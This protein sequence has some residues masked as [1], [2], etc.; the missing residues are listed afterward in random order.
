MNARWRAVI[1]KAIAVWLVII[2][3]EAAHGV[4]RAALLEPRVGDFRAR[5]I[6]VF[7]GSAIIFFI[8]LLFIRWICATS[9]RQLIG[10]GLLWLGLTVTFEILLGRLAFGYSWQRIL[11]DYNLPEG[12]LLGIGMVVLTL[13][14]LIAAKVRERR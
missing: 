2:I 4:S 13:S 7:T 6:A 5:Q 1:P 11:S 14:P 8:T 10:I 3:A 12:G 9:T